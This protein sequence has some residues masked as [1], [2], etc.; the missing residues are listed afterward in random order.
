MDKK[1]LAVAVVGAAAVAGAA[2]ISLREP[3]GTM[4]GAEEAAGKEQCYGVAKKGENG[5]A[6]AD[7][8][9]TCGGLATVDYSGGEWMPVDIGSCVK[10]GGKLEAFEGTGSPTKPT[11]S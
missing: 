8:S 9:H 4:P 3:V 6:A 11:G 7:G 5:C 1:I 10:M 2:V